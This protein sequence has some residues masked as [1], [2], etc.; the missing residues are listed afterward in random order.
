MT[1]TLLKLLIVIN[2]RRLNTGFNDKG[3]PIF[4]GFTIINSKVILGQAI[5]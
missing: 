4:Y 1:E 5:G 3:R 2:R